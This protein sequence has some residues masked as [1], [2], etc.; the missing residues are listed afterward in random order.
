MIG[1]EKKD[2]EG[3]LKSVRVFERDIDRKRVREREVDR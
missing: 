2:S 1:N 3:G